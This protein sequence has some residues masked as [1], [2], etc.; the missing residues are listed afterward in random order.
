MVGRP[1]PR[2]DRVLWSPAAVLAHSI[3]IS[4]RQNKSR[5]NGSVRTALHAPQE[6]AKPTEKIEKINLR[7][8]ENSITRQKN[9]SPAL[10][11]IKPTNFA[12]FSVQN[13]FSRKRIRARRMH[14]MQIIGGGAASEACRAETLQVSP[15]SRKSV[16][17]AAWEFA[18]SNW[19]LE[20]WVRCL[21]IAVVPID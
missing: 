7:S 17:N 18:C 20:G 12:K 9:T 2:D 19:D 1:F 15:A 21:V 6:T 10:T 13:Y 16:P 14:V 5:K 11:L 4:Q 3:P 8:D